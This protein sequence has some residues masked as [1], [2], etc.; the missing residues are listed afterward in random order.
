[1]QISTGVVFSPQDWNEP[2]AMVNGMVNFF[3]AIAGRN[4][5]FADTK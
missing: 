2:F 1:M 4:R 3:A 5:I